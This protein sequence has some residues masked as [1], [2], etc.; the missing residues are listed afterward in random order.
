[1]NELV[2]QSARALLWRGEVT[3]STPGYVVLMIANE[4]EISRHTAT[5]CLYRRQCLSYL[6]SVF[7]FIILHVMCLNNYL[8]FR[9]F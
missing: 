5:R 2:A 7:L 1:M 6:K 3:G 9:V 4:R 8:I